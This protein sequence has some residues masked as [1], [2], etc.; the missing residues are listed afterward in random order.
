MTEQAAHFLQWMPLPAAFGFIIGETYCDLCRH[1]KRLQETTE[2]LRKRLDEATTS[3]DSIHRALK[4]QRGVLND[5]H[6]RL[7]AV[8]KTL[9]KRLG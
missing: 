7:V 8:S 5:I 4:Q 3:N 6:S 9:E 2:E 1:R